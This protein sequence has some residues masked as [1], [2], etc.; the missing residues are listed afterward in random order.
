MGARAV[1]HLEEVSHD[2]I[3]SMAKAGTVAVLLPTTAYILRLRQPPA[4]EMIEE[5]NQIVS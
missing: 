4:R 1:S 5:G 2:G 3:T